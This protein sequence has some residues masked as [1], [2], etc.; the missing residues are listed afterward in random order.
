MRANNVLCT[1]WMDVMARKVVLNTEENV[2]EITEYDGS[3]NG[4]DFSLIKSERY[5]MNKVIEKNVTHAALHGMAQKLC[6]STASMSDK[7]GYSVEERFTTMGN[8]FERLMDGPWNKKAE[9]SGP[10]I[11]LSAVERKAK[12]L[13]L[14]DE[15]LELLKQLG[16]FKG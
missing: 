9:G 16:L 1:D 4:E 7:K 5:D 12:E 3:W 13:G 2:V 15:A 6:D 14:E 11:S 10:K 8:L